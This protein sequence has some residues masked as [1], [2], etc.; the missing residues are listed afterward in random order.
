MTFFDTLKDIRDGAVLGEAQAAMRE[1]V[2]AVLASNKPGKLQLTIT[3]K[4]TSKGQN[5]RT[6]LVTDD[7]KLITPRA[8]RGTTVFFAT[9]TAE[10]SRRDPRQ[11]RLPTMQAVPNNNNTTT[12]PADAPLADGTTGKA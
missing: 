11:P 5:D 2:E 1:L 6:L 9:D 3:V 12:T 7:L 10:L 4:P 8:E